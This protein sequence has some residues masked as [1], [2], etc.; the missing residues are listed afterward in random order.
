MCRSNY[1]PISQSGVKL[2]TRNFGDYTFQPHG[3]YSSPQDA[4]KSSAAPSEGWDYVVVT[5]K[6][7]PDIVDDSATI[8]P[9]V[10]DGKTC[11]VLIQNG[12]GI[13]TLHRARF[14]RNPIISGVTA[15]SAQLIQPDTVRQNRWTRLS[16]GPYSDG[17]GG[18]DSSAK[19][20]GRVGAE[21]IDELVRIFN[22]PGKL[23]D[24]EA[25]G[26]QQLQAVRWH[27]ICINGSM[28][29]SSVLCGGL[30]PAG[31][32]ANPPLRAHLKACM[33]EI[34]GAA[35]KVLGQPLEK[36]ATPEQ[37]LVSAGRNTGGKPSML[38]DW[39]AGRPMELEVILGNPVRIAKERG[40]EMPRLESLYALLKSQQTLREAKKAKEHGEA[41]AKL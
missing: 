34:F 31:M 25:H 33:Q 26:E 24:A 11:I 35:P 16:M 9:L 36:V 19:E 15:V 4:S 39:E 23:R 32:I 10:R 13:E 28:N 30:G 18:R 3:V 40:F 27:K 12:F 38:V 17:L 8:A 41:G 37:I 2:Q 14:P 5:T 29:P 7:L 21:R 20:L 1:K 22:G 6:A